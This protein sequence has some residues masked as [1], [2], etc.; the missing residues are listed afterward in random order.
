MIDGAAGVTAIDVNVAA[1]GAP[2]PPADPAAP[3]SI[4]PSIPATFPAA[5]SVPAAPAVPPPAPACAP[6]SV[7]S[8]ALLPLLQPTATISGA[9]SVSATSARDRV[10]GITVIFIWGLSLPSNDQPLGSKRAQRKT[11]ELSRS[12]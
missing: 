5:P 6:E 4:P 3:P 2:P 9:T 12:K 8:P 7:L 1:A 10:P 11:F